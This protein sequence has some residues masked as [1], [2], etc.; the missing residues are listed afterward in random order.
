MRNVVII[1]ILIFFLSAC[2]KDKYTTAPQ[3]KYKSA[4]TTVLNRN[5]TLKIT[6]SF[7]D[8]EGDLS[9][10]IFIQEIVAPCPLH[11]EGGFI[12]SSY[13]LPEFPSGKN[14][15]GEI[16]ITYD[17]VP[18]NPKCQRNDTAI[19]KFVLRDKAQ[20]LSDTAVSEPIVIIY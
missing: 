15:K 2:K 6:L 8:A 5:Q 11:P 20:H 17:Y 10:K 9:D 16:I 18:L 14:Q 12:D 13:H 7:T 1:S 19:F 3:L 4:N